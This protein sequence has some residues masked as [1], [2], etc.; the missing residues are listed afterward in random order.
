M[1]RCVCQDATLDLEY[2]DIKL[3]HS[4]FIN[5]QLMNN[6]EVH[7]PEIKIFCLKYLIWRI[8]NM[9]LKYKSVEYNEAIFK[10]LYFENLREVMDYLKIN[11]SLF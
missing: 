3:L 9:F 11:L 7:L 4:D 5:D 6:E 2:A 8:K 10:F 1:I